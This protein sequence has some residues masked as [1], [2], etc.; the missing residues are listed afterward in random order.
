VVSLTQSPSAILSPEQWGQIPKELTV[1]I[2]RGSLWQPGFR[3]RQVTLVTTLLNPTLYPAEQILRAYARRWRLEMCRDGLKTTLGMEML[4]CQ[5][6]A[7]V[8]K[9]VYLY[10]IAHNLIRLL[11]A[12][13]ADAHPVSLERMS[14]TLD[15]LRQFSQAMCQA[16][17]Q[18]KGRELW[19]ELLRTLAA[20]LLPERPGRREARAVKRQQNKY[21]RLDRPRDKFRDHPKRHVRRQRARLRNAA[22]K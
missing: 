15:A 1:R 19:D 13:A 9:E 14:G 20:D 8:Q 16:R 6:P 5:S 11:M 18:R 12:Q 21:P 7:M 3:V 4:R 17:S 10:L 22:L 2:V